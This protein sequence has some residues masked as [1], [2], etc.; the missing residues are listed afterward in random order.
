MCDDPRTSTAAPLGGSLIARKVLQMDEQKLLAVANELRRM[1][2]DLDESEAERN[3][4]A[5]IV[6][7]D[8]ARQNVIAAQ[9]GV[10]AD[11]AFTVA[12]QVVKR[13]SPRR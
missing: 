11:G 3:V 2:R 13:S 12:P 9:H 7:L 4:A 10:Q 8:C 5:A 1:I 6:Y